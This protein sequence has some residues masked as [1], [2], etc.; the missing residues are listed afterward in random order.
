M[1]DP[2]LAALRQAEKEDRAV[3]AVLAALEQG[4]WPPARIVRYRLCGYGPKR[5][6]ELA[7]TSV[8][9]VNV[10]LNERGLI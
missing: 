3:R 5:I 7:E 8:H 2:L 1:S 10:V 4:P 9:V 6:A